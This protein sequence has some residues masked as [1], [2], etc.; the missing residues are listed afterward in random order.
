MAHLSMMWP[1]SRNQKAG[2]GHN[3]QTQSEGEKFSLTY[4][5]NGMHLFVVMICDFFNFRNAACSLD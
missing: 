5:E 3:V 2:E 1:L 4:L